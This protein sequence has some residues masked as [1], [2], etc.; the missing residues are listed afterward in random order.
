MTITTEGK[1]HL[2]IYVC[3]YCYEVGSEKSI[4]RHIE[5]IHYAKDPA[6]SEV[7]TKVVML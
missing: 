6:V 7:I 3:G 2:T 4:V 1:P 5:K